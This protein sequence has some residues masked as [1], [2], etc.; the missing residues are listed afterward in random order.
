VRCELYEATGDTANGTASYERFV[1]L[2][3]GAEHALQAQVVEVWKQL[4]RLRR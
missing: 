4:A 3:N 1:Q 2:W